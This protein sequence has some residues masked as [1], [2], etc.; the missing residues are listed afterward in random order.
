MAEI[1]P[2]LR[3]FQKHI[4]LCIGASC[5]GEPALELYEYLK[6]KLK[7]L[8]LHQGE[9]RIARSKTTCLGVCS[10]GPVAVVYPDNI[11]YGS[12]NA[13]K[14][15]RIIKEHLISGEPVDEFRILPAV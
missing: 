3:P 6:A 11:W 1:Q 12:L 10:G 8:G 15:D 14:L 13:E 9:R 5:S 7:E 4:F 2:S